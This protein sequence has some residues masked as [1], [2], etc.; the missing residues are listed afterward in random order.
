MGDSVKWR[1][2]RSE[3]ET[4]PVKFE[5]RVDGDAKVVTFNPIPFLEKTKF[6]E[7]KS[8]R[9]LGIGPAES[10]LIAEIKPNG[11]AAAAGLEKG[12]R[13]LRS[14]ASGSIIWGGG[15]VLEAHS[16]EKLRL[17]VE[18]GGAFVAGEVT[19]GKPTSSPGEKP[20]M[21]ICGSRWMDLSGLPR[22][23]SRFARASTPWSR[24][25][26]PSSRAIPISSPSIWAA[27]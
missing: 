14:T 12:D 21:G 8:L 11:P 17:G 2:V 18:P 27:R 25:S 13:V 23:S 4:L 5:R 7:R 24:P 3:G 22:P 26:A 20:R 6:W 10:A 9:K 19:P 15:R 1:I 16:D